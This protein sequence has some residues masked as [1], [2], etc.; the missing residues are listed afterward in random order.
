MELLRLATA[1]SVDDGKSTLIGRLL[2]DTHSLFDDQIAAIEKVR[3]RRGD[4]HVNLALL[5]DG[6]KA[7]REQGITID[8]AYRYF[9]TRKRKFIL[10]DC[11]GHVQYTRNMITGVSQANVVILLIDARQ[12]VVEQTRRHS[13]IASLMRVP[14][15]VVCV[16][17]MDL[18]NYSE[19][20]FEKIKSEFQI[21]SRKLEISDVSFVP[22]SALNGDNVVERSTKMPWYSGRALLEHCEEIHIS[23]DEN[24]IDFRF[25]VQCV[26]RPQSA[27]KNLHDYRGF[28]GRILSGQIKVGDEVLVLSSQIKSRV[29]K[30]EVGGKEIQSADPLHS[31][32]LHLEDDVDISRG[33]LLVR[34]INI[35]IRSREIE[36]II[37][38]MA[39]DPLVMGKKYILKHTT[40]ELS[41]I[42]NTLHYQFDITNLSRDFKKTE[43]NMNGLARVKLKLS[44]DLWYDPFKLNKGTG[45]FI[46]VDAQSFETI[47]A[48]VLLPQ[49][50]LECPSISG[51]ELLKTPL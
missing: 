20:V 22:M 26:I 11:P 27:D 38:W 34:P 32:I 43:L 28:A 13:F 6:L 41:C 44:Q 39:Q 48:G 49:L 15:L 45:S 16:N 25:P 2:L 19:E 37:C 1:G 23:S 14:H 9:S 10:S 5:T 51:G 12:G 31:I 3:N 24:F 21:F 47:A 29:R 7:E 46:L 42:V 33:D 8:V 30:I 18:V 40:R 4:D 36:S 17:K 35:P 50:P